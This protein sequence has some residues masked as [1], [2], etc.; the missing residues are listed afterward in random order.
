MWSKL[1]DKYCSIDIK[2]VIGIDLLLA[3]A[4]IYLNSRLFPVIDYILKG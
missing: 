1:I 2:I 4:V 3:L